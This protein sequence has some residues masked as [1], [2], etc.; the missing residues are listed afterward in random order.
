MCGKQRGQRDVRAVAIRAAAGR[1][2]GHQNRASQNGGRFEHQ[3]VAR[4]GARCLCSACSAAVERRDARQ[5]R[6]ERDL[7]QHE[8]A[9]VAAVVDQ[10]L[11]PLAEVVVGPLCRPDDRIHRPADRAT[12]RREVGDRTTPAG[13]F[14]DRFVTEYLEPGGSAARKAR[15]RRR[16]CGRTAESAAR[17]RADTARCAAPTRAPR[18]AGSR[19]SR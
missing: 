16:R 6:V 11:V 13:G 5:Q 1:A 18:P 12:I 9:V 19:C 17:A 3:L 2:R 4:R 7:L 15:R 8:A 14:R 10:I